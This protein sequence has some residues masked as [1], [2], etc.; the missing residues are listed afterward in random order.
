MELETEVIRLRQRLCEYR[1]A[2]QGQNISTHVNAIDIALALTEL[3]LK[4]GRPIDEQE[5]NWFRAGLYLSYVFDGSE[6]EDIARSYNDIVEKV[7]QLKYF[8]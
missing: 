4:D 7:K 6:W 2:R 3:G 8:I 5:K 1:L